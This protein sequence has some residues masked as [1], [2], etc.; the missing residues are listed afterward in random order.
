MSALVSKLVDWRVGMLMSVWLSVVNKRDGEGVITIQMGVGV[1]HS[2][3][4]GVEVKE[5]RLGLH[6]PG[7][8]GITVRHSKSY[9]KLGFHSE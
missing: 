1:D 4:W 6:S 2:E 9:T 8:G 7:L 5:T 3:G